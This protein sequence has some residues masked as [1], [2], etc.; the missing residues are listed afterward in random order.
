MNIFALIST[1]IQTK[2]KDS[3]RIK[4]IES[5]YK[6]YLVSYFSSFQHYELEKERRKRIQDGEDPE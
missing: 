6:A 4:E 5:Q 2:M 3:I 1:A